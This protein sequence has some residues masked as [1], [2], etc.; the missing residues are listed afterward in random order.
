[1]PIKSVAL[2]YAIAEGAW[3][4]REWKTL[5]A[6]KNK[7]LWEADLPRERPLVYYFLA[8]DER[9]LETSCPQKIEIKA[10]AK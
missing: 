2:N 10:G 6:K 9:G 4:T 3:Q 1:M 7:D 5:P 8:V